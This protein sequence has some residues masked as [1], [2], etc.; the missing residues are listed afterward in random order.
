MYMNNIII[1]YCLTF[2]DVSDSDGMETDEDER[3]V[4][5]REA[6]MPLEDLIRCY[7]HHKVGIVHCS[8]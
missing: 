3:T 7:T 5:A 4:L 6:T 1:C 2:Q 8:C